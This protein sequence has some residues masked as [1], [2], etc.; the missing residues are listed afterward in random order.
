MKLII[1]EKPSV[2]MDY[3]KVLG[4]S[5]SARRNGYLEEGEWIITW[6]VGHLVS[7]SYP[8]AYDES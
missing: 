1:C 2:S 8:E 3:A 7:L 6:A 4:L 5:N